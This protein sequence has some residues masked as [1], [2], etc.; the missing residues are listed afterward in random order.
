MAERFIDPVGF[1][2]LLQRRV[3]RGDGVRDGVHAALARREAEQVEHGPR[4]AAD[5]DD[6]EAAAHV[7]RHGLA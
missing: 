2:A 1:H 7:E 4:I 3:Q 5:A 6:V